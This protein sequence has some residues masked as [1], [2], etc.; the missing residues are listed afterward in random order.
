ME[1]KQKAEADAEKKKAAKKPAAAEKT[2]KKSAA[3]ESEFKTGRD[4][5]EIVK[6]I[7]ELIDEHS[8]ED[9][10]L[11]RGSLGNGLLSCYPVFDSRN[12]GYRKLSD[13]VK[14][15][16]MFETRTGGDG[17][18]NGNLMYYIRKKAAGK[19]R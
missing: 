7:G 13:F 11:F 15:L 3:A 10:W 4:R 19:K 12:F 17:E 16:D 18:G 5:D 9:G 8:N 2:V 1:E 14:S 6:A